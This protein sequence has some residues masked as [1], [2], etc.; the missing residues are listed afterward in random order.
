M[1]MKIRKQL[2]NIGK[3]ENQKGQVFILVLIFMLVIGLMI[4]SA[5][6]L[7]ASALKQGSIIEDRTKHIYTADAGIESGWQKISTG[8][9]DIPGAVGTSSSPYSIN[10]ASGLSATVTITLLSGDSL[11]KTYHVHSVSTSTNGKTTSIDSQM[12][13]FPGDYY[14][15]LD[16]VITTEY[17]CDIKNKVPVNGWI[18]YGSKKGKEPQWPISD[19][20]APS[21]PGYGWR[22]ERPI[23]WPTSTSLTT[24]YMDNVTD[25]IAELHSGNWSPSGTLTLTK[26]IYV[27]GDFRM[28]SGTLNLNGYTLFVDGNVYIHHADVNPPGTNVSG[29]IVSTGN[30]EFWPNQNTGDPTHG[31]FVFCLGSAGAEFQPGGNYYGWIAAQNGVQ[32]KSGSGPSYNWVNPVSVIDQ[33]NFP[34]LNGVGGPGLPAGFVKISTWKIGY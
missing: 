12:T 8:S 7:T 16:N 14:Y 21:P 28:S 3:L 30:V 23:V 9:Y 33:L 2:R 4:S 32:L 34:G 26:T 25:G 31:V 18:A 13:A 24:Y 6:Q 29:C 17:L 20:G 19:T 27:D 1:L 11:S 15:F 5:L 22:D 10:V